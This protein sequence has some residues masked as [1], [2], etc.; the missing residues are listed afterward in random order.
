MLPSKTF[1]I[2][3]L[4]MFAILILALERVYKLRSLE[5]GVGHYSYVLPLRYLDSKKS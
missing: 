2:P 1:H 4:N 5:G 3:H